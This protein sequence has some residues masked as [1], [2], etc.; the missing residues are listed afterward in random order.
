MKRL[1]LLL[2]LA[3]SLLAGC[4]TAVMMGDRVLGVRSGKF[5]YTDGVLE[6]NYTADFET[7]WRAVEQALQK[8]NATIVDTEKKIASGVYEAHMEGEDIR[9]TVE[10]LEPDLTN[11]G[12]RVGVAGNNLASK[13]IHSK[14]EEAFKKEAEHP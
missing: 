3:A 6:T 12:V 4:N 11:V 8:M 10:Y 13:L 2:F 5:F 14:I 9:I 7:T 1:S